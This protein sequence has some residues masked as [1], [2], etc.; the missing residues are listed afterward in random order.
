M[1]V[2][3]NNP[4]LQAKIDRWVSETGQ[5]AD[6]LVEDAMAGYL[7]ELAQVRAT[8]D[9]RYDDIKTGK[10]TLIDGEEVRR[11][12]KAQTQAQRNLRR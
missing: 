4:D 1:D 6:E 3:L 10:V 12:M 7:D 8:I 2:H 5:P 9:H 11:E